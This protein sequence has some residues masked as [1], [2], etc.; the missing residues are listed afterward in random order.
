[1]FCI[2]K[3]LLEVLQYEDMDIRFNTDVNVKKD[4]RLIA[5][6]PCLAGFTMM[7]KLWGGNETAVLA[8]IR[9]LSIADLAVSVNRKE[10]IMQLDQA[11]AE[12]AANLLRAKEEFEKQ[13]GKVTIFGPGVKPSDTNS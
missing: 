4:F 8:M 9:T 5:E 2:M 11:S 7:T 13:G 12:T 3:K 1:M 6:L 10:M